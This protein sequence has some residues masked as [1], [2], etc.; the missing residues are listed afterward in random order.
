MV[1]SLYFQIVSNGKLRFFFIISLFVFGV[2][3]L[4]LLW[5]IVVAVLCGIVGCLFRFLHTDCAVIFRN[6]IVGFCVFAGVMF[7][8]VF[9]V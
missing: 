2:R 1:L 8:Y 4:V 3:R 7:V 5:F 9:V 6:V